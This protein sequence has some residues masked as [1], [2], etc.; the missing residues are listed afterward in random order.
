MIVT[1]RQTVFPGIDKAGYQVGGKTGTSQVAVNGGYATDETVGTY[2][3]FGGGNE[4]KYVIMVEVS[5]DHKILQ[6]AKDAMPIFTDISNWLL[7]YLQVPPK[8]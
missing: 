5:G 1:G 3:G 8:G 2:L 7:D 4:A 6:G